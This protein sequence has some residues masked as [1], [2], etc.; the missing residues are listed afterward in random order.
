MSPSF[1]IGIILGGIIIILN[2][3]F[4]QSTIIKAFQQSPV[5]RR[6][7]KS[8]LIAKSFLRLFILGWIIFAMLKYKLVD[9]I[10]LAVGL[11]IIFLSIVSL[12]I[13]IAWKSGNW[14]VF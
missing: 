9:P 8:L 13:S 2:F 6:K 5:I 7:K 4:L 12:G 10:G 3:N 14:R 1:T 11:S